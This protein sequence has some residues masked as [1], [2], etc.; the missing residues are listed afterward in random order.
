MSCI[1]IN[2]IFISILVQLRLS[3]KLRKIETEVLKGKDDSLVSLGV[4]CGRKWFKVVT[5]S[6][7]GR[8]LQ[9]THSQAK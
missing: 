8:N 5:S 1:F 4:G 7:Y 6:A 9:V 3:E 2:Y